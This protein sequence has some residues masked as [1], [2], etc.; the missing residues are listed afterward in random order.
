M[1]NVN[2]DIRKQLD[3]FSINLMNGILSGNVQI[4]SIH[5]HRAVLIDIIAEDDVRGG[6][7]PPF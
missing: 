4:D 3:S 6:E 2:P 7:L 5:N 1:S